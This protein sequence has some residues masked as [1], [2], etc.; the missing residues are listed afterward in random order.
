MTTED[1]QIIVLAC[2]L[3]AGGVC[4]IKWLWHGAVWLFRKPVMKAL[5]FVCPG[6]V[7]AWEAYQER[8]ELERDDAAHDL[9]TFKECEWGLNEDIRKANQNGEEA[10]K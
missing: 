6:L 9:C 3:I 10:S 5:R 4:W 7:A 1:V 8:R 2:L